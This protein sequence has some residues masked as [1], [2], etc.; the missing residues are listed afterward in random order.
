MWSSVVNLSLHQHRHAP[1]FRAE[2]R[3]R[4][5]SCTLTIRRP[6][7]LQGGQVLVLQMNGKGY[8]IFKDIVPLNIAKQKD[9]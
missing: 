4:R 8:P 6:E 9:M 1:P 2:K 7:G 5:G 3:P